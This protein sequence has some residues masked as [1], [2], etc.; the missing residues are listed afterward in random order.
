M[1]PAHDPHASYAD[2]RTHDFLQ[3][4]YPDVKTLDI[5]GRLRADSVEKAALQHQLSWIP[6]FFAKRSRKLWTAVRWWIS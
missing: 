2:R 6:M 1:A 5:F 3:R 4:D